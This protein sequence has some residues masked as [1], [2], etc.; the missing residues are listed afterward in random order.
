MGIVGCAIAESRKGFL[1]R[2]EGLNHTM[3]TVL[4]LYSIRAVLALTGVD[5]EHTRRRG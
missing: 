4:A 3:S 2:S 5:S 1:D